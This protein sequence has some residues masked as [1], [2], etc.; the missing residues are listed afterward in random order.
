MKYIFH[1]ILFL[2]LIFGA[3]SSQEGLTQ[4]NDT[5]I[6]FGNGGGYSGQEMQY[7]LSND[8]NI[9]LYDN[10]T[11]QTTEVQ[12]LKKKQTKKV[13]DDIENMV[14][15]TDNINNPGNMYYFIKQV[16]GN[17]EHKIVWGGNN[18][19][20]PAEVQEFYNLL[21]SYVN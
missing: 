13:F 15:L 12:K 9:T 10:I 21:M 20:V 14:Q 1:I 2:F 8:G 6:I 16:K 17:R 11:K 3:C 18:T 19:K 4:Y 7:T 5:Q